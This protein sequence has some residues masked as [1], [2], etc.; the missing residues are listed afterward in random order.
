MSIALAKKAAAVLLLAGIA[1]PA[2]SH[3]A[4][5]RR[6]Q[7]RAH[8]EMEALSGMVSQVQIAPGGEQRVTIN[9]AP[10]FFEKHTEQG[11]L[12]EVM[13]RIA[14]DCESGS[15]TT[16]FGLTKST[17][18]GAAKPVKLERVF[19]QGEGD[20]RASLCIFANDS[21]G[22]AARDELRRVRYTLAFKREDGSIG[23]TTVVSACTTPLQ[24]MFPLEGDAP[25]SDAAEIARPEA[26]RRTLT[27]TIGSGRSG[28]DHV[29]RVYEST[30]DLASSVTSYDR[31]MQALGYTTTGSL[32]DAR[33]YRRDGKSWAASFQ[34]TTGG[35]TIAL[36]PFPN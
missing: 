34:G 17:D 15:E 29:I 12:D 1:V 19:S 14:K 11:T 30:L 2:A 10:M 3:A 21:V 9:G 23:V 32:E 27:A 36:I 26:S 4:N 5:E 8:Q 20:V 18:D 16:A 22:A 33:M 24:E 25:G 28:Q 31:A 6:A 13:G 7:I 35:S